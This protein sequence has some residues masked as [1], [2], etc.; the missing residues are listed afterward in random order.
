MIKRKFS[1]FNIQNKQTFQERERY[2]VIGTSHI[3]RIIQ[4]KSKH[5]AQFIY[6][7]S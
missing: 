2:G 6:L 7:E 1:G 4:M 3:M 5:K